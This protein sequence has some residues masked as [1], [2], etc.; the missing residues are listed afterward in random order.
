MRA[1][2]APVLLDESARVTV[3]AVFVGR[4]ADLER[5]ELSS[6]H[7]RLVVIYGVGGIGK[8][9]F[10]MKAARRIVALVGGRL[11]Y[12]DCRQGESPATLM[13]ALFEQL[14]GEH[15][16]DG[17]LF[18]AVLRHAA[19]SPLVLCLDNAHRPTDP[20]FCEA[21][22]LLASRGAPVWVLAA[23]RE[24]LPFTATEI[25]HVVV[26]LGGLS[27]DE[28][29]ALWQLL[30]QLY[31]PAPR[32]VDPL[33]SGGNPLLLKHR[34]TQPKLAVLDQLGLDMLPEA[35]RDLLRELAAF[36]KPLDA[37]YLAA[38]QPA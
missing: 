20:G 37:G 18:G 34:F 38:R 5:V 27:P 4:T 30:E 33:S 3:P 11:V 13:H 14:D 32:A 10:M 36:R 12:H 19:T 23:A 26:R 28:S 16:A 6:H 2:T 31:G 9:A 35:E 21:L 22:A 29:R 7:V 24:S 1:T 25:D 8:T 15:A 17:N